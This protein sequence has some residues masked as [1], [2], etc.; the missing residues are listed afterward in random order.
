MDNTALPP[1]IVAFIAS[2]KPVLNVLLVSCVWLGISIP[3]LFALFWFST[4]QLRR[5]PI[6]LFNVVSILIGVVMGAL[7][8]FILVPLVLSYG[9]GRITHTLPN[10]VK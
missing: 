3:L 8:I 1:A 2:I 10:T 9:I 5:K 6:F 4:K 7:N